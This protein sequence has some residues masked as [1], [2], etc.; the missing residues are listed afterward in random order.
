MAT[1]AADLGVVRT[2]ERPATAARSSHGAV[3][4]LLLAERRGT[5]P[6]ARDASPPNAAPS[7]FEQRV[8]EICCENPACHVACN[9]G[10]APRHACAT[11]CGHDAAEGERLAQDRIPPAA[12]NAGTCPLRDWPTTLATQLPEGGGVLA[13]GWRPYNNKL[14]QTKPAQAMVLRC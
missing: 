13:C 10:Q 2:T 4:G 1:L 7:V 6:A 8:A 9:E 12:R 11:A 14:Q 3:S 5:P